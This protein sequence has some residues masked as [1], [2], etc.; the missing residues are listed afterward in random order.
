MMSD[1]DFAIT[2]IARLQKRCVVSV[3]PM[4]TFHRW[5]DSKRLARQACRVVGDSRTGKSVACTAYA[6]N[7]PAQER[8]GEPPIV[9]VLYW[10]A[11]QESGP[12]DFF[13]GVLDALQYQLSRGTL[14]E[15]R[16]RVYQVL[17]A[18]QVELLI[19]DEAHRLRPKTFSDIQDVFDKLEIAVVLVGTDR[20]DA[21]VRRDEQIYNRF[22]ACHRVQR[23]NSQQLKV[24][25]GLWEKHVLQLPEPSQLTSV[26]MQ[27]IL[28][29][30]TQG[31][32]GLLDM[33]LR[34]AAITSLE[35]GKNR[36]SKTILEEVASEYR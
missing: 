27:R 26:P 24:T 36:I 22:M 20:L 18:C 29:T 3:E 12:R 8:S 14:S 9:P 13:E 17:R 16:R 4:E 35:R 2:A 28:N 23:L 34:T 11:P 5:L 6:W 10:H 31:Y 21:V 7:H 25:T 15:V 30:T 19:V 33:V 1:D 32:I